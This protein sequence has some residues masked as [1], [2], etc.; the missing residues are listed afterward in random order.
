MRILLTIFTFTILSSSFASEWIQKADI[1][2]F[3]RHRCAGLAIGN[4][5]YAGLGHM[6]GTGL[7]IVYQDWWEFDPAANSWT[8]KANYPV[9]NYGVA[10]FG[11]STHG[12]IGG[13]TSLTS[14]F[15]EYSPVTNTWTAIPNAPSAPNDQTAFSVNEKGYVFDNSAFY[16]YDPQTQIWAFKTPPPVLS[17]VWSCSF[18]SGNSGFVKFG[19]SLLEYKPSLDQWVVRESFPGYASGGSS[20]FCVDG[21]GY[22]ISGYGSWLADL[23]KE[24]WRFHV[25]TNTWEQMSDFDGSG[26]RFSI[27]MNVNN[28]GY[29]GFGTN[30]INFNDWWVL[31]NIADVEELSK[32]NVSVFPNPSTD[33]VS[34]KININDLPLDLEFIS[35]EGKTIQVIKNKSQNEKISVFDLENG[36]YTIL[37]KQNNKIIHRAQFLKMNS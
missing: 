12:Y 33:F 15:F 22:I 21:F 31:G 25:G 13:G 36:T 26:R 5:A 18:V 27:G 3:G 4:K 7:N 32:V 24:V 8:Q 29:F 20:S 11:T 35:A 17:S 28:R 9:P 30:G 6:N 1:S 10:A 2:N 34:I 19:S 16:E 14:E 37:V 23:T